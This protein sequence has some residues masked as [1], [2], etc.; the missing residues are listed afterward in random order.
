MSAIKYISEGGGIKYGDFQ[1]TSSQA[2]GGFII[3]VSVSLGYNGPSTA[4]LSIVSSRG[5]YEISQND[6]YVSDCRFPPKILTF[7]LTPDTLNADPEEDEEEEKLSD[8]SKG[9]GMFMYPIAYNLSEGP[10]GRT[11]EV[12]LVEASVDYF[13]RTL[14]LTKNNVPAGD[15]EKEGILYVGTEFFSNNTSTRNEMISREE[16]LKRKDSYP[17]LYEKARTEFGTY[18]YT[19]ADL[20]KELRKKGVPCTDAMLSFLSKYN[21]IYLSETGTLQSILQDI[22]TKLGVM[23]FWNGIDAVGQFQLDWNN[24]N[25]SPDDEEEEPVITIGIDVLREADITPSFLAERKIFGQSQAGLLTKTTQVSIEDTSVTSQIQRVELAGGDDSNPK[26]LS[27]INLMRLTPVF[28][29][30]N[31]CGKDKQIQLF[32]PE[33][34]LKEPD[35]GGEEGGP[36]S[37]DL[38]KAWARLNLLKAIALGPEFARSYILLKKA[39]YTREEIKKGSGEPLDPDDAYTTDNLGN[40][41]P[42]GNPQGD[43]IAPYIT[44]FAAVNEF[45]PD[46]CDRDGSQTNL[47]ITDDDCEGNVF[48]VAPGSPE[49]KEWGEGNLK[50]TEGINLPSEPAIIV[51][52]LETVNKRDPKSQG[53]FTDIQANPKD[54]KALKKE[55]MVLLVRD[56]GA[57]ADSQKDKSQGHPFAPQQPNMGSNDTYSQLEKFVDNINSY[58]YA[59]G[60]FVPNCY[61]DDVKDSEKFTYNH[62]GWPATPLPEFDISPSQIEPQ[63][64]RVQDLSWLTPIGEAYAGNSGFKDPSNKFT[65]IADFVQNLGYNGFF[66]G[67]YFGDDA[68]APPK[69]IAFD[70]QHNKSCIEPISLEG[71]NLQKEIDKENCT[72]NNSNV[73]KFWKN[74]TPFDIPL[75]SKVNAFKLTDNY[76]HILN[77]TPDLAAIVNQ[78]R[79]N[80]YDIAVAYKPTGQRTINVGVQFFSGRNKN[81][82]II[83]KTIKY[84]VDD[85][86]DLDYFLK[87]VDIGIDMKGLPTNDMSVNQII[88]PD[89]YYK[90]KGVLIGGCEADFGNFDHYYNNQ[91]PNIEVFDNSR[92]LSL[93]PDSGGT[94]A[95]FRSEYSDLLPATGCDKQEAADEIQS[96]NSPYT[97]LTPRAKG[98]IENNME[99][100]AKTQFELNKFTNPTFNYAYECVGVPLG[101]LPNIRD[102]LANLSIEVGTD[103]PKI[104]FSIGSRKLRRTVLDQDKQAVSLRNGVRQIDQND[105]YSVFSKKFL[106]KVAQPTPPM[107]LIKGKNMNKG[108]PPT[109]PSV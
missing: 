109:N 10:G 100:I 77:T 56:E 63:E 28:G 44:D 98:I 80:F 95:P 26:Y 43:E 104:K 96:A 19:P 30:I 106:N 58:Y 52:I 85:V 1:A 82:E 59:G 21:D 79:K 22:G 11:L 83:F 107:T 20:A 87:D 33:N 94:G 99:Q 31:I 97:G 68:P 54:I 35:P 48:V 6:L 12:E 88:T 62:R 70:K 17:A 81:D 90:A 92:V 65:A 60:S 16:I 50:E 103:G 74:E 14:V 42:G 49:G 18:Y 101:G 53:R 61:P 4:T 8:S 84:E 24:L 67:S 15:R 51:K 86:D 73:I 3:G 2:Y 9:F 108:K 69:Y 37:D 45:F 29:K 71:A 46:C 76:T 57:G 47:E 40:A 5:E 78:T 23:F 89:R 102:G 93:I 38:R 34:A 72:Y 7:G 55:L 32:D 66:T 75:S 91:P 41:D 64:V 105:T 36:I 27:T 13:N 39:G 25:P